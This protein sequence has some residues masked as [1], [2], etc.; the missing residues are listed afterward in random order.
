MEQWTVLF[1]DAEKSE[2]A[3]VKV[4]F[5]P[6]TP[7]IIEFVVELNPIP[8]DDNV[9]KDVTVNWKMF[10]GF[11]ANKTFWSDSN[12]LEMQQRNIK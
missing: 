8:I 2:K 4:R 10:N 1:D 3:I 7:E 11:D 9:G 5:S 6:L 12:G